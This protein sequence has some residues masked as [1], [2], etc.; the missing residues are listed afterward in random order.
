[1]LAGV[2]LGFVATGI[3]VYWIILRVLSKEGKAKISD[4][5]RC[6]W[7]L[8]KSKKNQLI[9]STTILIKNDTSID[10]TLVDVFTRLQLPEEQYKDGIC[11][12]WIRRADTNREDGYWEAMIIPK[13]T[14]TTAEVFLIIDAVKSLETTMNNLPDFFIDLYWQIVCRNPQRVEWQRIRVFADDLREAREEEGG[15]V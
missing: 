2:L 14:G 12:S 7:K 4:T 8:Q 10:F 9:F 1:M 5:E 11:R 6:S 13:K 3:I 15:E